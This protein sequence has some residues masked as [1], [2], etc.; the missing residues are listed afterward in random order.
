MS[1]YFVRSMRSLVVFEKKTCSTNIHSANE[2]MDAEGE[3]NS[4]M[5]NALLRICANFL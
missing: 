3:N 4:Y 2:A 5:R 1:I